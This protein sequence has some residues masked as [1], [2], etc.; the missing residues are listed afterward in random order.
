MWYRKALKS[1]QIHAEYFYPTHLKNDFSSHYSKNR[2][3]VHVFLDM[4][5]LYSRASWQ[6]RRFWISLFVIREGGCEFPRCHCNSAG[7]EL[8]LA[9]VSR[10]LQLSVPALEVKPIFLSNGKVLLLLLVL[11]LF[12]FVSKLFIVWFQI[13]TV[14]K[15]FYCSLLQFEKYLVSIFLVLG[16]VLNLRISIT[17]DLVLNWRNICYWRK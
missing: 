2:L 16:G 12:I 1:S 10:Y 8:E 13:G 15:E 14:W 6:K 17:L 4:K 9:P 3:A 11:L 5:N 7:K